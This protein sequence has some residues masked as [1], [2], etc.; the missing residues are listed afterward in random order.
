MTW[1]STLR[2]TLMASLGLGIHFCPASGQ[3]TAAPPAQQAQQSTPRQ[4]RAQRRAARRLAAQQAAARNQP[5][6]VI[7]TATQA[8]LDQKLLDQ[9]KAQSAATAK[10]NDAVTQ[11]AVR[12]QQKVQAEQRIQD[13][14]GPGSQPLPGDPAVQPTQPAD[15]PR[16]QDAPGPTQTLPKAPP[17]PAPQ[18]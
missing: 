7:S 3:Q 4:T 10:E 9:Q 17:A 11:K 8:Q 18:F 13:A 5:P 16:I 1:R 15:P 6:A 2:L 14:P 12:D